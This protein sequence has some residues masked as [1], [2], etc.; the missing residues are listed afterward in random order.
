MSPFSRRTHTLLMTAKLEGLVRACICIYTSSV[1]L[2]WVILL[3]VSPHLSFLFGFKHFIFKLHL[4]C[5]QTPCISGYMSFLSKPN[6]HRT[7][8]Y[9]R[10]GQT[11]QKQRKETKRMGSQPVNSDLQGTFTGGIFQY[12]QV[13]MRCQNRLFPYLHL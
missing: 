8:C 10:E 2:I 7:T 6:N 5:V 11:E 1:V 3:F 4:F 13:K 9:N 12:R